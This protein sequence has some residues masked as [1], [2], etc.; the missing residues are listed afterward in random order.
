VKY[1]KFDGYLPYESELSLF[2]I[3]GITSSIL[4]IIE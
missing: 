2:Y 3:Y 1:P 4:E